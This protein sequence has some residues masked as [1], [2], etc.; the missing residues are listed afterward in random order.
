[1]PGPNREAG[2]VR[3]L[4]RP[5]RLAPSSLLP[6]RSTGVC[7]WTAPALLTAPLS[8]PPHLC[9]VPA[10][11]RGRKPS[12]RQTSG[13]RKP[14]GREAGWRAKESPP[15]RHPCSPASRRA[16]WAAHTARPWPAPVD[17]STGQAPPASARCTRLWLSRV[18][19]CCRFLSGG[20]CR[21]QC[22]WPRSCQS[23]IPGVGRPPPQALRLGPRCTA[24]LQR[25]AR[26]HGGLLA[27]GPLPSIGQPRQPPTS[28][29]PRSSPRPPSH[30][31]SPGSS[32][33]WPQG[34]R[35]GQTPPGTPWP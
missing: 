23:S 8:H 11:A 7:P 21:P 4:C 25:P 34:C 35:P 33:P 15:E 14:G 10:C 2:A 13:A 29:T 6:K 16:G 26:S 22:P 20:P 17:G 27:T 3:P 19:P 24:G 1:M 30:T 12:S 31:E 9:R 28:P 5:A 32:G 18:Q